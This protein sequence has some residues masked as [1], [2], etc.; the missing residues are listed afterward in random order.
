MMMSAV[1]PVEGVLSPDVSDP[2]RGVLTEG[3]PGSFISRVE[4]LRNTDVIV[5]N[6]FNMNI[7]L[8]LDLKHAVCLF[9]RIGSKLSAETPDISSNAA[10]SALR[11]YVTWYL[12]SVSEGGKNAKNIPSN[13]KNWR[14][15]IDPIHLEII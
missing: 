14:Y 1:M 3:R 5:S 12:V 8:F 10:A 11:A 15:A 4:A 2:L 13:T 9:F 6:H 7:N